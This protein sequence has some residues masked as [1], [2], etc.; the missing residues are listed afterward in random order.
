MTIN[1][2]GNIGKDAQLRKVKVGEREDSVLDM[3]V[4]EN[5]K[6]RSGN[7]KTLWHKVTIW[8]GYAETMAQYLKKGRK[9]FVAGTAEASYY[10]K[11][12]AIHPYIA[13]QASELRLLD[14]KKDED[15]PP[16]DVETEVEETVAEDTPW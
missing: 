13:V 10:V 5:I 6:K 14:A 1:F 9:V 7:E 12:G 11:D 16:E 4:A 15:L 3:W 8:R 2:I